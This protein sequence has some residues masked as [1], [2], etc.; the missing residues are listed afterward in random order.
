MTKQRRWLLSAIEASKT[1]DVCLPWQRGPKT[2][3]LAFKHIQMQVAPKPKAA[4]A[5]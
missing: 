2:R 3:P 4:A 5:R 1:E